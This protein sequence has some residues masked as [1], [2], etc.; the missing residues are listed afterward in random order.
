MGGALYTKI[1]INGRY[2]KAITAILYDFSYKLTTF[3]YYSYSFIR[4]FV[5]I[6]A[7][8]YIAPFYCHL[9]HNQKKIAFRSSRCI[10]YFVSRISQLMQ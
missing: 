9:P 3:Y 5:Q 8:P 1:R 10:I 4:Y 6:I 2:V 7:P